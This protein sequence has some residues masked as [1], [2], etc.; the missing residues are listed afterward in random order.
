MSRVICNKR[1]DDWSN[2][3]NSNVND[4]GKPN[5]NNSN[6]ENDNDARV[7]VRIE[8][9]LIDAFTPAADLTASFGEFGLQFQSVCII[10]QVEF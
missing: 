8:V 2:V 6:A 3:P 4:N 5:L 10:N 1:I 7:L 9:T